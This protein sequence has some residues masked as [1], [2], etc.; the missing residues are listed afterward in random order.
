MI[1]IGERITGASITPESALPLLALCPSHSIETIGDVI[2]CADHAEEW[3]RQHKAPPV[4]RTL[5]GLIGAS[6]FGVS[7][8]AD[9]VLYDKAVTIANERKGDKAFGLRFVDWLEY[10]LRCE[11]LDSA[12]CSLAQGCDQSGHMH[13]AAV[14]FVRNVSGQLGR[15]EFGSY[16]DVR[17]LVKPLKGNQAK[18]GHI[19]GYSK[20][21]GPE[22]FSAARAVYPKKPTP[23]PTSHSFRMTNDRYDFAGPLV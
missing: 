9:Y 14:V 2:A 8:W 1:G 19:A 21:I 6:L 4:I 17:R 7:D 5:A 13:L 16:D 22:R 10:V 3:R 20:T 23:A 12:S 11:G 18:N 15:V